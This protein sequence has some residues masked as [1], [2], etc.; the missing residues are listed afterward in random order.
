MPIFHRLVHNIE[1][2]GALPNSFNEAT[3]PLIPKPY[4]VS[5]RKENYRTIFLMICL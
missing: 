5:T 3:T 2:E 4:N 1:T